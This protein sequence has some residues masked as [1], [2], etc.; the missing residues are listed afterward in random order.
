MHEMTP[1]ERFVR[2]MTFQ[3]VDR[4]FIKKD[5]YSPLAVRRWI[6]EGMPPDADP[7]EYFGCERREFIPIHM[8]AFPPFEQEIFEDEGMTVVKRTDQGHIV[9]TYKDDELAHMP[10]FLEWPVKTRRDFEMMKEHYQ[11]AL[12]ER[13]PA[14][15]GEKLP[16]WRDVCP[17][18][19]VFELRGLFFHRLH[20]WMGLEGL[21]FAM[22]D[23]PAWV[24][25]MVAFLE[26]FLLTV[27]ERILG[28][29]P[30]LSYVYA[31]DDI[32]YKTAPLISPAAFREFLFEPT[33]RVIDRVRR[34]GVPVIMMDTDGNLDEMLPIYLAAG[35]NAV[36]PIEIAANNDP[37]MIRRRYRRSCALFDGFDKRILSRDKKAIEQEILRLFPALMIEGGFIPGIDHA[38]PEDVSLENYK[39]YMDL[40]RE[41]ASDPERYLEKTIS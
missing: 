22:H 3:P 16:Y 10:Q 23:D 33:K 2:G 30:N 32:A 4:V 17:Y 19:V 25:E 9:R 12:N 21:C 34:S 29:N 13:Y 15:Y 6:E 26:A 14:D 5:G 36:T 39:F 35:F 20:M 38:V 8:G 24:H 28:D 1:R 37:L 7:H 27:S 41:V 31:C 11:P 18:P 40:T